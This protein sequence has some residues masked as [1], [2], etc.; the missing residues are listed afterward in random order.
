MLGDLPRYADSLHS[1]SWSSRVPNL[2]RLLPS[3]CE[4]LIRVRFTA[5]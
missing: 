3:H 4:H 2:R 5:D 1:Y